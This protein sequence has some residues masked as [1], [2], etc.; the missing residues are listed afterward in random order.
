MSV[1]LCAYVY[2][3]PVALS[4]PT[5]AVFQGITCPTEFER[6]QCA[7]HE[8]AEGGRQTEQGGRERERGRNRK[9]S[10]KNLPVVCSISL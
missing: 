6:L 10:L 5:L 8:V 9:K 4:P 7:V 2:L 1:Y 3:C